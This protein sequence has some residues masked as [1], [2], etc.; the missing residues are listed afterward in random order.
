MEEKTV[1]HGHLNTYCLSYVAAT[2][3]KIPDYLV[4]VLDQVVTLL[5][6][7]LHVTAVNIKVY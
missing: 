1:F 7:I 4:A 3:G 6:N 5:Q 2:K